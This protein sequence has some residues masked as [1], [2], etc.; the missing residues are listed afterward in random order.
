MMLMEKM[1]T[2]HPDV[3]CL[4]EKQTSFRREEKGNNKL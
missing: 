4:R 3:L 2:F 1:R